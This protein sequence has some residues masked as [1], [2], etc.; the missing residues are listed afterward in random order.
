M[1]SPLTTMYGTL[2]KPNKWFGKDC[3]S[4]LGICGNLLANIQKTNFNYIPEDYDKISFFTT[5]STLELCNGILKRL[6]LA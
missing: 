3:L 5:K 6:M 2:I 1:A 4:T